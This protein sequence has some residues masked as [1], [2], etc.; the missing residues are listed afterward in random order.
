MARFF[1]AFVVLACLAAS[2]SAA[3]PTLVRHNGINHSAEANATN[4]PIP[5]PT[6]GAST[7]TGGGGS[8]TSST[9]KD[10][11]SCF[12]A[13]AT[14]VTLA[15][16]TKRMDELVAGD[17]VHVGRGQFSQVFM[18]THKS[19]DVVAD[20]VVIDAASSGARLCLTP[21]HYMY[22]NGALAAAKTVAV[23]DAIELADGATDTV[24]AVSSAFLQ[25]LYNPQTLHGDIVVDSVRVSTYTTA[26][27]PAFAHAALTPLRVAYRFLGISPNLFDEGSELSSVL[28][29]GEVTL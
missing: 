16:T 9:S 18:F 28:P 3:I 15:G 24:A 21:G 19:A 29:T 12:P 6:P 8:A 13:D 11:G 23:G 27:A 10:S 4:P 14:V 25:G 17:R 2:V 22:V 1:P 20:F 5:S 26:V 7:S